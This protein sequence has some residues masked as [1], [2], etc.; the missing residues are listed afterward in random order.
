MH[1]MSPRAT[2]LLRKAFALSVAERADLAGSLIESLD[3]ARDKSVRAAWDA[4]VVRRM[5]EIDSGKVKL[6]SLAQA[7]RKLTSSIE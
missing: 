4:E 1:A 3:Q 6:V 5:E 7:R 2:Y